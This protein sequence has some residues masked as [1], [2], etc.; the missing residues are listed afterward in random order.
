VK[1]DSYY[2][3]ILRKNLLISK[4]KLQSLKCHAESIKNEYGEKDWRYVIAL[5]KVSIA[6]EN[7]MK[8]EYFLENGVQM[9][10]IQSIAVPQEF[11]DKL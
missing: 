5:E 4:D 10:P 1:P 7:F 11:Q 8:Q 2:E 9:S 6:S 3:K